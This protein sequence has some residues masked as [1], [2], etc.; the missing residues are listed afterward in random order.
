MTVQEHDAGYLLSRIR[1]GDED[2]IAYVLDLSPAD[3]VELATPKV[4]T[5]KSG[6]KLFHEPGTGKFMDTDP[7][8]PDPNDYPY[9][10]VTSHKPGGASPLSPTGPNPDVIPPVVSPSGVPLNET[11]LDQVA[12]TKVNKNGMRT[13]GTEKEGTDWDNVSA[14]KPFWWAQNMSADHTRYKVVDPSENKVGHI[15]QGPDGLWR[16]EGDTKGQG[17]GQGWHS[18][19]MAFQAVVADSKRKHQLSKNKLAGG[20][21][22]DGNE[23][24]YL[25]PEDTPDSLK[26][27][28]SAPSLDA[29]P[30]P[31]PVVTPA[32]AAPVAPVAS[33]EPESIVSA[34]G[35]T[36]MSETFTHGPLTS[37]TV[38]DAHTGEDTGLKVNGKPG[39]YMLSGT[40]LGTPKDKF[41][42]KEEALE[43]AEKVYKKMTADASDATA[44]AAKDAALLEYTKAIKSGNGG[45]AAL[46]KAKAIS[47]GH[48]TLKDFDAV[49]AD[50]YSTVVTPA[51]DPAPKLPTTSGAHG[52]L[53]ATQSGDAPFMAVTTPSGGTAATLKINPDGKVQ[54]LGTAYP[55]V[56]VPLSQALSS[57]EMKL[58]Q[59]GDAD[60]VSQSNLAGSAPSGVSYVPET[61]SES[62]FHVFGPDKSK[63]GTL[64]AVGSTGDW[65]DQSGKVYPSF[66]AGLEGLFPT[67][68]P[69]SSPPMKEFTRGK[70]TITPLGGDEY[71]V[72]ETGSYDEHA[73]LAKNP[74][75]TWDAFDADKTL[76]ADVTFDE[77]VAAATGT[78]T[79][80]NPTAKPAAPAPSALSP[81]EE[82]EALSEEVQNATGLPGFNPG[83]YLASSS[84]AKSKFDM[85][86]DPIEFTTPIGTKSLSHAAV[87]KA[88]GWKQGVFFPTNTVTK[89]FGGAEIVK[90]E[91]GVPNQKFSVKVSGVEVGNLLYS[92]KTGNFSV[93]MDGQP[94]MKVASFN[95]AKKAVASAVST[96]P[97][98]AKL[99]PPPPPGA[100]AQSAAGGVYVTSKVKSAKNPSKFNLYNSSGAKIGEAQ[101]HWGTGQYTNLKTGATYGSLQDLADAA[102]SASPTPAPAVPSTAP[103]DPTSL[104]GGRTAHT[105]KEAA[106]HLKAT[107][108]VLGSHGAKVMNGPEGKKYLLKPQEDWQTKLDLAV[109]DLLHSHG[110]PAPAMQQATV[111]GQK[112]SLQTMY[113]SKP[114]FP[115]SFDPSSL[116]AG[117]HVALQKQMVMD[118]LVGNH[119]AHKD[120]WLRTS[121]GNLVAID[122]GQAFKFGLGH[123]A[124]WM[125]PGNHGVPVY[126][127]YLKSAPEI[128]PQAAALVQAVSKMTPLQVKDSFGKYATA[129]QKAGKL[130]NGMDA[131][132]FLAELKKHAEGLPELFSK[133]F[134][135]A[136]TASAA[137]APSAAPAAPAASTAS[138]PGSYKITL[139]SAGGMYADGGAI[140]KLMNTEAVTPSQQAQKDAAIQDALE[141]FKAKHGKEYDTSKVTNPGTSTFVPPSASITSDIFDNAKQAGYEPVDKME[142][143]NNGWKPTDA[144]LDGKNG[145]YIYSGGSYAAINAQLRKGKK[146]PTGGKNDKVIAAMDKEFAAA[147]PI[148]KN[149]VTVRKMT[150]GGPFPK[151]PPPMTAGHMFVDHGYSSTSKTGTWSGS[152]IMEVRIPKGTKVLDLNHST[153]SQ[154]SSEQEVL[155]NRG[156]WYQ[157]VGDEILPDGQRR[158]TVTVVNDGAQ[159]GMPAVVPQN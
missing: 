93:F 101:K 15:V 135:A 11:T 19:K 43:G 112:G 142:S 9:A 65:A 139:P 99:P 103:K 121:E 53:T 44:K 88:T 37:N 60:L 28:P 79:S 95:E 138:G 16:T 134:P 45:G 100:L 114:A 118:L 56:Y 143:L 23:E 89:T 46:I 57:L 21:D 12:P 123:D 75:G 149:T 128:T 136:S 49:D 117:D 154:H 71:G 97:V 80:A 81:Q 42:T 69:S 51:F 125:P 86:V 131:D 34:S 158:I 147:P 52:L 68:S 91:S 6:R 70:Y 47:Q 58:I 85:G 141:Q 32:P 132:T 130:P 18:H 54:E 25:D 78:N 24:W 116:S 105:P 153:G 83:K 76:A 127:A 115:G 150:G 61:S 109:N 73:M 5:L 72:V 48:A 30:E 4:T 126:D 8:D 92:K 155:L 137:P 82:I 102:D 111:D 67:P 33:S 27:D 133:Q 145:A 63:L 140:A 38:L 41:D 108:V 35:D 66:D 13:L 55:D 157:V 90:D 146:K 119:D 64:S 14:K 7:S 156:T 17:V 50:I 29:N 84:L 129:A 87:A 74:N 3:V 151:N 124:S 107:G 98:V 40:P 1:E 62:V 110:M 94:M 104:T 106:A 113:D 20:P 36:K 22:A 120:Q 31:D 122:Q 39:L 2:A 26:S 59:A 10:P 148:T 96:S 159:P 77:A 152:T 144:G